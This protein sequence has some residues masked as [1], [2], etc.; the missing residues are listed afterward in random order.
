MVVVVLVVEVVDIVVLVV[1]VEVVVVVIVVEVDVEV[2]VVVVE[3]DVLV[4]KGVEVMTDALVVTFSVGLKVSSTVDDNV[5]VTVV[6]TSPKRASLSTNWTL[7]TLVSSRRG[8][9]VT[10]GARTPVQ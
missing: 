2:E 1:V 8:R 4:V 10:L 7:A 9:T 3:V 6:S 5:G